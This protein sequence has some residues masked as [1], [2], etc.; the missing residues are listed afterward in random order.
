MPQSAIS[1]TPIA[2]KARPPIVFRLAR[3]LSAMLSAFSARRFLALAVFAPFA[4]AGLASAT[5]LS[6]SE[7]T[8]RL[9]TDWA[10]PLALAR[11]DPTLGTLTQVVLRFDG[12]AFTD[13]AVENLG[14]A[15]GT[16]SF[17][18]A[19]DF[20]LDGLGANLFSFGV[21]NSGVQA[22]AGFDG[23]TDFAGS[24]GYTWGELSAA[25]SA[26]TQWLTG[27]DAF[28]GPGMLDFQAAAT[29]ATQL[30]GPANL[31][32]RI[33]TSGEATVTLEYTYEPAAVPET[34]PTA[35]ALA[36]GFVLLAGTRRRLT[37]PEQS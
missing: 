17:Q 11:F 26:S 25:Q 21:T 10:V 18:N 35:A 32:S 8:G 5:T 15:P 7:A 20:R 33:R 3:S 2:L 37:R 19:V 24:S 31:R 13:A 4:T 14:R 30:T 22:L 34:L 1:P 12:V 16:V 36:A 29:A 9:D 28:T 6:F 27:L 23:N